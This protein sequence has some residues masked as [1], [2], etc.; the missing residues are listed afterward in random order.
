MGLQALQACSTLKSNYEEL[1]KRH[2]SA[3]EDGSFMVDL[4]TR[5]PASAK[6]LRDRAA[7]LQAVQEAGLAP[8]L[9]STDRL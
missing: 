6:E 2:K 5:G 4:T 9:L 3:N 1:L 8:D 7:A